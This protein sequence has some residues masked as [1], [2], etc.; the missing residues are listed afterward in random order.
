MRICLISDVHFEINDYAL[1]VREFT[2]GDVLI[3]AG[4]LTCAR[5]FRPGRTDKEAKKHQK[6]FERFLNSIASKFKTCLYVVGNHEHYGSLFSETVDLLR[7]RLRD[8]NVVLLDND[9][10]TID[11]VRFF[12]ATLWTSFN[13]GS[14]QEMMVTEKYMNDYKWIY[15]KHLS[16]LTYDERNSALWHVRNGT[17]TPAQIL[18]EHDR[19]VE[20]LKHF[21]KESSPSKK[22]VVITHHAPSLKSQNTSRHGPSMIHAYCTDLEY[23]MEEYDIS[24]WVHGHTHDSMDYTVGNTRVVSNQMGY[25]GYDP[26]AWHFKPLYLE[27]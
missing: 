25:I 9:T 5:F 23:L 2:P 4:D 8:T 20:A 27:V 19:S 18:I 17:I 24:L 14:P 11:D 15:S 12:G 3:V 10:V 16:E 1:K 6:H 22:N 13:S 7:S 26:E 21:L